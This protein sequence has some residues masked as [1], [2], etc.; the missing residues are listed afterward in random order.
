MIRGK[1]GGRGKKAIS[2]TYSFS[3]DTLMKARRHIS[4]GAQAMA[5]AIVYPDPA[6]LKRRSKPGLLQPESDFSKTL[7]M[8]ART[9]LRECE[10]R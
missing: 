2:S 5:M 7:L 1:K 10:A 4:K 3:P 8:Q 9:V 6:T